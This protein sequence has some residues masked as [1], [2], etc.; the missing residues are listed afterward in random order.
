[1]QTFRWQI[2]HTEAEAVG[3]K[4]YLSVDAETCMVGLVP[5]RPEKGGSTFDVGGCNDVVQAGILRLLVLALDIL[6]L[7]SIWQGELRQGL[8]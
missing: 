5:C 3:Q 6:E 7:F 4:G 2:V 1:M 8:R